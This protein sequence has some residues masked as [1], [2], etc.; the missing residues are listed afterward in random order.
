MRR[1]GENLDLNFF[2]KITKF[3]NLKIDVKANFFS[4]KKSCHFLFK[5]EFY[6]EF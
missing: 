2:Q 5:F 4:W 6:V 3:E 1:F